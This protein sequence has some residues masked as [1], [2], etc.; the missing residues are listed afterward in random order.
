MG[1]AAGIAMLLGMVRV[2]FAAVLIGTAGVGLNASFTAIQTLISTLA[3]LGLQSSAVRDIAAAVSKDDQQEIGRK[4][5]TLRRICWL[6]G[7][8]GMVTMMLLSPMISQITFGHQNYAL[9]I[10][11]LGLIILFANLSGGQMA[12]IQGMR[13]IGDIARVNVFAGILATLAG[14][15]F[16]ATLG[17]KGIVPG[18]V[19]ASAAQLVLS[20]YFARQVSVPQVQ[21]DIKQ[22]FLEANGMVRLGLAMMF[23]SLMVSAVT[24][25][26]VA[27]IT[28]QEGTNAVGLYSAAFTLS[29]IFVNFVLGAMAADYY[30]R[31]TS[32]ADDSIEMTRLVNEQTEIAILLAVPG[33]VFTLAFAPWLIESL[34]SRE[35]LDATKLLQ[36]FILG[37]MGRVIS[38]PLGFVI[39]ALGKGRWFLLT[40]TSFNLM[41]F[42]MI[43]VVQTIIFTSTVA[44]YGFAPV[45]TDE[46][47]KIAPF[48]DYG[49]TKF[50]A[51]QIFKAW[52]AEAPTERTLV[53]IRPTVVF[54]EQN[55]GNVYNLLRQ[56]ASGKFVMIGSGE[57]RKSMAYVENVAAFIE[58]SMSFKAGVHIYNFIDKPDFA[59][60]A[61]VGNVN[62]IL[63]RPERIGFRLP[64]A[65][66]YLIGKGFDLA[67]AITGKRFAISSIRVKKF[68]AN[69]VYNT[70]I[71]RTGFV[72]PVPL[73][74]AL[75]QTVRYE[76][77]ESH[78]HEGVFYTE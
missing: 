45:G 56:I 50:K 3:G 61:L 5:L 24:Y 13:R 66:G 20:W 62:R 54:G 38:W 43:A 37:C 51:E 16:Y 21:L 46:S 68:C 6:T 77:V 2:K 26:T 44:V 57:N 27:L 35:F 48:N 71:D 65:V 60:N 72:P 73:E 17:L 11:E 23:S 75:S 42:A 49:R 22:T 32:V 18:L 41:H 59:M 69:S 12:L 33:L 63:G 67:A 29:G 70:A 15:G 47:G 31:L 64:F 76:F 4:V 39:L 8:V 40:E 53:I 1:G 36:W 52:Q 58:Y 34:Y 30:P 28:K 74:Q 19:T 55:R 25:A 78:E 14:I 7:L 9:D 10:A